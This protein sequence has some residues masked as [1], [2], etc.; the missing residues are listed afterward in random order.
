MRPMIHALLIANVL[1]ITSPFAQADEEGRLNKISGG[2]FQ[3]N[4]EHCDRLND[5]RWGKG[6]NLRWLCLVTK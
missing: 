1:L 6:H 5:A 3:G 4:W 2:A